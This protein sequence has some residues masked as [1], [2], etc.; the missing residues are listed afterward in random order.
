MSDFHES[1]EDEVSSSSLILYEVPL[2]DSDRSE[3]NTDRVL[4]FSTVD[5][6]WLTEAQVLDL[7][8]K[9]TDWLVS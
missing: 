8:D 3:Y 2:D 1:F 9:L 7:R 6:P 4:Q 5:V